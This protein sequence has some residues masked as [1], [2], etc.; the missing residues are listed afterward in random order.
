MEHGLFGALVAEPPGA[1]WTD[2]HTG[3]PLLSGAIADIHTTE[4]VGTDVRGS[5]REL[6]L[7]TQDGN[8]ITH[9][10]KSS[11]STFGLRAEPLRPG[12]RR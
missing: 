1:T 8:Q 2:P 9:I 11:G 6:A 4:P 10:G 3:E 7:F 5:F 12:A